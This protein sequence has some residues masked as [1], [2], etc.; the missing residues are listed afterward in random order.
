MY[1][2]IQLKEIYHQIV[3]GTYLKLCKTEGKTKY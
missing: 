3:K 1:K 2:L